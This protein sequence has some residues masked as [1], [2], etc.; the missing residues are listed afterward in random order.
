[1]NVGKKKHAKPVFKTKAKAGSE[2]YGPNGLYD[3]S[4]FE[5][6]NISQEWTN[7][8]VRVANHGLS[9]GTWSSYKTA[10]KALNRCGEEANTSMNFPL[11]Q[12]QVLTFVAWMTDRGLSAKTMQVYLAGIRQ[13]HLVAGVEL[14]VIRSPLVN[15]LIEGKKH[16]DAF[17]KKSTGDC[18]RLP[19]TP[20]LMKLLKEEIRLDNMTSHDKLVV[21]AVATLAFNG[22]FRIHELLSRKSSTY[23]PKVTLLSRDI[24]I[25]ES[26][27][28]KEKIGII[29]VLI[30][31]EKKDRVGA[32]VIV[33]VYESGGDLCPLKA[34]RKWLR[35]KVNSKQKHP[36]FC[37]ESG[38]PLT[39]KA[40][41]AMLKNLLAKHLKGYRRKVTSHSFRAGLASLMGKLGF[42]DNDIMAIGRWSSRSFEAY[43]KLPRSKRLDM[44]K[45]IGKL[46]L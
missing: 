24:I 11:K 42:S 14:P 9:R 43:L 15:M 41:N 32:G 2:K 40:F 38:K 37:L 34:L 3:S 16:L 20:A 17:K 44:A 18:S 6:M 39:G 46:G 1:M 4:T 30:K 22:A 26:Y 5:N 7:L 12:E 13:C 10:L 19:M 33:D 36:A 27:L 21:W 29:Q 23:D 28:G 25:K 45:K 8:L 31:S 35:T